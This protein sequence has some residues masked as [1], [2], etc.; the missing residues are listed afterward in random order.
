MSDDAFVQKVHDKKRLLFITD[1]QAPNPATMNRYFE[2]LNGDAE[3]EGTIDAPKKKADCLV[4]RKMHEYMDKDFSPYVLRQT[5]KGYR[6]D[7]QRIFSATP[8]HTKR[9]RVEKFARQHDVAIQENPRKARCDGVHAHTQME[10]LSIRAGI[11]LGGELKTDDDGDSSVG[12]TA[13]STTTN[14]FHSLELTAPS[15]HSEAGHFTNPSGSSTDT[16]DGSEIESIA[17]HHAANA[18]DDVAARPPAE[19]P[20]TVIENVQTIEERPTGSPIMNIEQSRTNTSDD[21]F[22]G[23]VDVP[24]YMQEGNWWLFMLLLSVIIFLLFLLLL[25]ILLVLVQPYLFWLL[26]ANLESYKNL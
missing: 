17:Q 15:T 21:D 4:V 14:E 6:Q 16:G 8:M 13:P 5:K 26:M 22:I 24:P 23:K 18:N 2:L 12:S 9:D 11:P 25:L 1:A 7:H 3:K 19:D 20:W 10:T